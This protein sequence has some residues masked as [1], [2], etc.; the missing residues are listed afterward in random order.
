M[1]T[2]PVSNAVGTP[3]PVVIG[4]NK[5]PVEKVTLFIL[6]DVEYQIPKKID[7]RIGLRFA[8][9]MSGAKTEMDQMGAQL[10]FIKEMLGAEA[11]AVLMDDSEV[12]PEDFEAVLALLQRVGLGESEAAKN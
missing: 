4:Q 1:A 3:D 12:S 10:L 5:K 8:E 2:R 9:R 7:P 11:Y 6:N